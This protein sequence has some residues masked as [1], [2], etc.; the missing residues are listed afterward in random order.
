MNYTIRRTMYTLSKSE[1]ISSVQQRSRHPNRDELLK[2]L[3]FMPPLYTIYCKRQNNSI[4]LPTN[5]DI[6]KLLK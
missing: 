1:M 2:N 5:T 6:I 4:H 3:G